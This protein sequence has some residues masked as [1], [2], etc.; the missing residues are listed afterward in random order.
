[1]RSVISLIATSAPPTCWGKYASEKLRFFLDVV[2]WMLLHE[3]NSQAPSSASSRELPIW[4][5]QWMIPRDFPVAKVSSLSCRRT[6]VRARGQYM[7]VYCQD[8]SRP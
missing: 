2:I 5:Y 4:M 6:S 3:C 7:Y 1:M 8:Q